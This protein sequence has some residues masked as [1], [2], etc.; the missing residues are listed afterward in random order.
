MH[1]S[2]QFWKCHAHDC[3]RG[4]VRG[5]SCS[6]DDSH[7]FTAGQDGSVFVWRVAAN[8]PQQSVYGDKDLAVVDGKLKAGSDI[9]DAATY[10]IQEAKIKTERNREAQEAEERKMKARKEV[11]A[12]KEKFAASLRDWK[13][14]PAFNEEMRWK[15]NVNQGLSEQYGM[16]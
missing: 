7:Y 5:V 14:S 10:S 16:S 1:E 15:L 4:A 6:F 2:G 8:Q 9:S 11:T 3:D 13:Q 12:V